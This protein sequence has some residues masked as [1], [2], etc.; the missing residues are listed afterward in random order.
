MEPDPRDEELGMKSLPSSYKDAWGKQIP[1]EPPPFNMVS[2]IGERS[3]QS[4]IT[5]VEQEPKGAENIND[6]STILDNP[7]SIETPISSEQEHQLILLEP[8]PIREVGNGRRGGQGH[9]KH[10]WE[11]RRRCGWTRIRRGVR[12]RKKQFGIFGHFVLRWICCWTIEPQGSR[13]VDQALWK[14]PVKMPFQGTQDASD[15]MVKHV[16]QEPFSL[17]TKTSGKPSHHQ[18]EITVEPEL[19]RGQSGGPLIVDQPNFIETHTSLA[20]EHRLTSLEPDQVQEINPVHIVYPNLILTQPKLVIIFFHGIVSR[21]DISNAWKETWTSITH[22]NGEERPTFWIKEWLVED[23]GENIQIL[24]LSYD[25]NIY[26]VNDDVTDIGKNLVQSLVVNQRYISLWRAPI[27]L[28]GHSFGGLIIKSLVVEIKRCMNKK[29]SNDIESAM[30]ERSKDFYDNLIGVIF[31]GAPHEGGTKAFSTYFAQTCQEMGI[32]NKT[33]PIQQSLLKNVQFLDKT[34]EQLSME[35]DEAKENLNIYAFVE[36]QPINKDEEILVPHASAQ[37]LSRN[38]YYKIEDANHLTI[39]KPPTRDHISYSKLVDCLRTCLKNPRQLPSLPSWEVSLEEK[40]NDTYKLLQKISI[41]GLVGMG[42]I[43]KTTLS[44]KIYHL[45]QEQYD[46]SSFLEDVKSKN[47]EDLKKQLLQDLCGRKKNNMEVVNGDDL[48]GIEETMISKKVL[49]VIDDVDEKLISD[50]SKVL[51]FQ[52]KHRKS[53]VIVTCRNWGILEGHLDPNGRFEVPYL[54]KKQ[55]LELFLSHAFHNT[56]Q[57]EKDFENIVEEIVEAC[58]GLPLSLEV[59]GGFLHKKKSHDMQTRLKIWK[60]AL[61][62]LRAG[63]NLD[64]GIEDILWQSLEISYKDLDQPEKDMFLD[65]AC[66]F[67]GLKESIALRIWDSESSTLELQ[68]LKDRSL[69][70]VEKDGNL[71]IHDQLRDMGRKFIIREENN[72]IWDLE[73]NLQNFHEQEVPSKLQGAL[74]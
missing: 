60:G 21:K 71:F 15:I 58:A 5:M 45:F 33:H 23:M 29:P 44:K 38:N 7:T 69:V 37:R 62:K 3:H 10:A 51:A 28:V 63:N 35:F 53:N 25:A 43:G 41:I 40:A 57:V 68:N 66:Y 9:F 17:R 2:W 11:S 65:I 12:R 52:G 31:Y 73:T 64:G 56:K 32:L 48:K 1:P 4:E 49:V 46:K 42:G 26:G 67:G 61:K 16:P 50:L 19:E 36:G 6:P 54:N 39:C 14:W 27:V 70:K 30:N 22:I 55:A 20:Q 47:I 34:M 24:S 8:D 74:S 13:E 72:R 18:S 59:M